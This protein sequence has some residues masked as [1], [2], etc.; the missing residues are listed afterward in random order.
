[1]QSYSAPAANSHMDMSNLQGRWVLESINGKPVES[2]NEIY[3]EIEG[4][5]I[6]GF[7]GCNNF[8][9]KLDVPA[10]LRMTQRAC[11]SEGPRLPLELPD[12]R[13]QLKAAEVI[14][15]KLK[16]KLPDRK[17]EASFRRQ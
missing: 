17:G 11:I 4:T 8:G 10:S 14:G 12:A 13:S 3:F 15:K 9:G 16:L 7:D 6:T 2:E 1:M 5:I